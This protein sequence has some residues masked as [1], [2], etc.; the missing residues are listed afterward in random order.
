MYLKKNLNINK[1]IL[2]PLYSDNTTS[3]NTTVHC[4]ITKMIYLLNYKL[5]LKAI[6][7]EFLSLNQ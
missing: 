4:Y 1:T 6:K 3:I 7:A 2:V 5:Y